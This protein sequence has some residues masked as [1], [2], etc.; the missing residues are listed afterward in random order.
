LLHFRDGVNAEQSKHLLKGDSDTLQKG[1]PGEGRGQE[2]GERLA[3]Y[4]DPVVVPGK[5]VGHGRGRLAD[6][7][8]PEVTFRVF[9]DGR[10]DD[11]GE[12]ENEVEEDL[13][14]FRFPE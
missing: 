3:K 6:F 9:V 4:P 2:V 7:V 11:V 8:R 14:L 1:Q 13:P 10:A 12:G 5:G